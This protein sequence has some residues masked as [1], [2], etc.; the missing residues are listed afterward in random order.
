MRP[1]TLASWRRLRHGSQMPSEPM[2]LRRAPHEGQV[3]NRDRKHRSV[4]SSPDFRMRY[5]W[6]SMALAPRLR[7]R[8]SS[9]LGIFPALSRRNCRSA[10]VQ[11]RLLAPFLMPRRSPP[12]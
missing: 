10:T 12:R 2:R 1:C 8:D 5:T 4:T 7:A 9:R 6:L 11:S 3:A